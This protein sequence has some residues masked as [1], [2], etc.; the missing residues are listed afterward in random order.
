MALAAIK[1]W[2]PNE[3]LYAADLVAEFNNILQIISPGMLVSPLTAEL[4]A[5]GNDIT[6][7]D[8]LAFNDASADPTADGRLRRNGDTL[9]F[10]LQ[11]ARTATT[12][13]PF[14][15]QADTTGVPAAS[16]GIGLRFDAESGD[17]SPSQFGAL[18]FVATDVG[19]GT[20]DT[21]LDVLLRTA[22]AALGT[23][24]RFQSLGA[25]RYL[26]TGTPT[27]DRTITFPDADATIG[28]SSGLTRVGGTT[29]ESTTNS[30]TDAD[31][32]TIS[33][34]SIPAGTPFLII[35]SLR[36]STGAVGTASIGLKLNTTTV[37]AP[38][39]WTVSAN[40]AASSLYYALVGAHDATLL[41]TGVVMSNANIYTFDTDIPNATITDIVIRGKVSDAGITLGVD[42]VHIFTFAVS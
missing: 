34:L 14:A 21:V 38:D 41:R 13:R 29:T 17:E 27:A 5:G 40:A 42:E 1:V 15:L 9:T 16:I 37:R 11:D 39:A 25:F 31:V 36:K 7:L 22:G 3:V 35:A 24:Y 20:E 30:T 28:A 26:F 32:L 2:V 23:R 8:E 33:G 19:A 18:D 4:A 6:G 12:A 10:R